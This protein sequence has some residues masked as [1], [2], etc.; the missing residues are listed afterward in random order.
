M[1]LETTV[2]APATLDGLARLLT[3]FRT[4]LTTARVPA[5]TQRSLHAAIDEL[6]ANVVMHGKADGAVHAMAAKIT[7]NDEDIVVELVD[8]GQPFDPIAHDHPT[9]PP[10][11]RLGGVGIRLARHWVDEMR[12][13][14]RGPHNHVVLVKRR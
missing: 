10:E 12:Y 14:R 7:C 9:D 4:F 1:T 8:N 3:S 2:D 6:L 5:T 13:E 11:L